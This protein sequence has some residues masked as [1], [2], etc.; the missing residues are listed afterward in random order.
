MLVCRTPVYMNPMVDGKEP[1]VC[2]AGGMEKKLPLPC[3]WYFEQGV[4][5]KSQLSEVSAA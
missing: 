5:V 1:A 3:K 2:R 4:Q